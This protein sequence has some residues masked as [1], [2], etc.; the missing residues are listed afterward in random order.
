MK[1]DE[2][3]GKLK[4][5]KKKTTIIA[6]VALLFLGGSGYA[7]YSTTNQPKE[8]Q[9]EKI[10]YLTCVDGLRDWTV[11]QNTE[12][13]DYLE[14]VKWN[15]EFIKEVTYDDVKVKRRRVRINLYNQTNWYR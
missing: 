13:V 1:K 5:N 6:V 8:V 11:E 2:I 3:I 7:I 10:D 14:G 9:Q 15:K 4:E 12:K